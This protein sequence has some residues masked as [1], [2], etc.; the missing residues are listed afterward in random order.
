MLAGALAYGH[1]LDVPFMKEAKRGEVPRK[2]AKYDVA[3]RRKTD[4]ML[5]ERAIDF[6]TRQAKAKKPFF[7]FVPLTQPHLPTLPHPDFAGKT[8][9][10]DYADVTHEIDH[11]CGQILD[12][13]DELGIRDDTIFIFTSD[14]GPEFFQP[15]HGTSG[16][17]R[18]NYFTALEG[19]LRVPFIVRWPG[20][21]EAGTT[22]N[23]IVHTVDMLPTLARVAGYQ[24]PTDRIIDGVDQYDFFTGKQATSN[25]EGF[26]VYN[27]DTLYAYKWRNWKL[28]LVDLPDM[29]SK[30]Q[31][32]LVPRI[33]H[34]LTDPKELYNVN[35]DSTWIMPVVFKKI[36]A[37]QRS[38]AKEP[39]I[40]L[41]TPDPY[42]PPK[43]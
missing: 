39:P 40:R 14:N 2:I 19:S 28:H 42:V 29:G 35:V 38:L 34:L 33:Y 23:E 36:I 18:G 43:R 16:Y 6:M 9:N 26:P 12:A 1:T 3:Q 8:G 32:Y 10:G 37:F 13:I 22:S 31:R 41:G 11:R 25:R 17:W 15:F 20:R 7:A 24:P 30:P 5:T 21:I 27:G 4:G